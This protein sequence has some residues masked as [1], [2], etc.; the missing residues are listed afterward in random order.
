M[1]DLTDE[2]LAAVIAALGQ[3]I[4]ADGYRHSPRLLPFKAALAKLDPISVPPSR[5]PVIMPSPTAKPTHGKRGLFFCWCGLNRLLKNK[6]Q[7]YNL[8]WSVEMFAILYVFLARDDGATAIEYGLIAALIRRCRHC[9][10][11][12][13]RNAPHHHIQRHCGQGLSD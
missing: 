5:Q 3:A 12:R 13:R 11:V 9:R 4:D 10:D 7:A 8:W 6:A 1:D 2:E